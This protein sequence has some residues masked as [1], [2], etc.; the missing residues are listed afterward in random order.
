MAKG[1]IKSVKDKSNNRLLPA[2]R[3]GDIGCIDVCENN[4]MLLD[5]CILF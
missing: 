1:L 2:L 3:Y 4:H 5:S